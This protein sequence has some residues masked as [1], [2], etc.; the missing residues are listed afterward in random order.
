MKKSYTLLLA[1]IAALAL[2]DANAQPKPGPGPKPPQQHNQPGKPGPSKPEPGKPGPGKPA[3]QP[4]KPAPQPPK[5]QPPKP[6]PHD[7]KP[8]PH[9]DKPLPPPPPKGDYK[10]GHNRYELEKP[11][12]REFYKD[13]QRIP[14]H[15][16]FAFGSAPEKLSVYLRPREEFELNLDEDRREGFAWFARYDEHCVKVDIDHKR[17]K[18]YFFGKSQQVAEVEI[19]GKFPCDTIV[20]LI[21]ANRH[22]WDNGGH[23]DKVIRLFVHID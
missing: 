19:E 2:G 14:N 18:K 5:P 11:H 23:P 22:D 16:R 21:Y 10:P 6:A 20:E 9:P 12:A 4:P 15:K 17:G 3:P 8:A 1:A 7:V 13:W